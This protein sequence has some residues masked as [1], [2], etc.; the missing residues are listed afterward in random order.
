LLTKKEWLN[1][2]I[3]KIIGGVG[4]MKSWTREIEINAPINQVWKL[5]DGSLEDMQKIM[6]QVVANTPVKITNEKV[7]SIYRQKYK[8]G[9]RIEEYEV[10]TLAYEN[11]HDLKRL[12][13][14]F[15]LANMFDITALYELKRLDDDKTLFSYTVTNKALKWFIKP[16]L[17]FAGDKV[18][19]QFLERVKKVA[20]IQTTT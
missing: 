2:K 15:T 8:E 9:K 3:N 11:H 16:F 13:V 17:W 6:P 14:G 1:R 19:V 5:L 10:K 7:G 20:E 4:I 18:V 12:T